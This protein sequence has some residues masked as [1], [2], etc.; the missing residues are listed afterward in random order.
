STIRQ[1]PSTNSVSS[2]ESGDNNNSDD[3]EEF[4][5]PQ[6][7]NTQQMAQPKQPIERKEDAL[8]KPFSTSSL[9]SS[10]AEQTT[11]AHTHTAKPRS[12]SITAVEATD[13][14]RANDTTRTSAYATNPLMHSEGGADSNLS[15]AHA[16]THTHT[17]AHVNTNTT[18]TSPLTTNSRAPY[19]RQPSLE[20]SHLSQQHKPVS[21]LSTVEETASNGPGGG[22]GGSYKQTDRPKN[23]PTNELGPKA[24]A[25]SK[26]GMADAGYKGNLPTEIDYASM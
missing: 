12:H 17:H 8:P 2:D 9:L 4:T 25:G 10:T 16:H 11:T 7:I 13:R 21:T 5:K 6:P 19:T 26:R 1:R 20:Q 18:R 22:G 24:N 3:D 23:G 15:Y 14:G